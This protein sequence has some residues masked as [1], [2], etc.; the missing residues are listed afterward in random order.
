MYSTFAITSTRQ[1]TQGKNCR[2]VID[3]CII[4]SSFLR[5]GS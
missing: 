2:I 1:E 5:G 3:Y 4:S